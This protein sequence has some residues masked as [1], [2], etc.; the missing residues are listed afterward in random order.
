MGAMDE[1]QAMDLL[2]DMNRKIGFTGETVDDGDPDA[3]WRS[4]MEDC[5]DI[6]LGAL[7]GRPRVKV[8]DAEIEAVEEW[9]KAHGITPGVAGV[10]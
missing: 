2:R 5:G 7:P 4:G 9:V 3:G 1:G 8:A 6:D 10:G